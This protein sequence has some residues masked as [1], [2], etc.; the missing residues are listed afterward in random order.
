MTHF[1][2][3]KF[4]LYCIPEIC[5]RSNILAGIGKQLSLIIKKKYV[6]Y[7]CI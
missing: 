1:W 3:R 5:L 7:V 2:T 4:V 6:Q